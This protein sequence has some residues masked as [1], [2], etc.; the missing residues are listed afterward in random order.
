VLNSLRMRATERADIVQKA[1]EM[2]SGAARRMRL[3][4]ARIAERGLRA[5]PE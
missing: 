5:I 4:Q 2:S 3:A 1:L